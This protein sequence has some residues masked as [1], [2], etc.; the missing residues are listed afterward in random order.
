MNAIV[1]KIREMA[2]R[3]LK[4]PK[5]CK[6]VKKLQYPQNVQ[7][8]AKSINVKRLKCLKRSLSI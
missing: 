3:A 1:L 6:R 4:D 7:N 2:H 8:C 5:K